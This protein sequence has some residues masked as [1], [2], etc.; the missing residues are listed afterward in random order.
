MRS[1]RP[2]VVDQEAAKA[3]LPGEW[4]WN[5]RHEE[6]QEWWWSPAL[7]RCLVGLGPGA[8]GTA[9]TWL[10]P[11]DDVAK[12]FTQ[13]HRKDNPELYAPF[14]TVD[15]DR[16]M[17]DMVQQLEELGDAAIA[18]LESGDLLPKT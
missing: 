14:D 10:I 17:I 11:V 15:P 4:R 16:V 13:M 12:F 8:Y 9:K 6:A 1:T 7:G 18:L 5:E 2:S 3:A